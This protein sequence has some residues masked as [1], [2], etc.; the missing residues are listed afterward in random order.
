MSYETNVTIRK[1]H[2]LTYSVLNIYFLFSGSSKSADLGI[3]NTVSY[4][5][6]FGMVSLY[7]LKYDGTSIY[8]FVTV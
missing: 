8:V 3:M 5:F 4:P 7:L 1:P 6:Q 2:L